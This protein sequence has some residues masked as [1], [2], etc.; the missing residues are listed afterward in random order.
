MKLCLLKYIAFDQ[1]QSIVVSK[2]EDPRL[3]SDF[4]TEQETIEV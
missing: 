1:C 3:Q 2:K 4:E